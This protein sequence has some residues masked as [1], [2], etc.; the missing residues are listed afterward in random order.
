[1][2]ATL[3]AWGASDWERIRGYAP[4]LWDGALVTLRVAL[5]ALALG[6]AIGLAVAVGSR[7]RLLPVRLAIGAYV[8]VGRAVPELVQVFIWYYVLPDYGLVLSPFAAGV[9]AIGVAFGPYLGEVFRAGVESVDRTQ[10]EA[11]EVL[12][13]SRA[14]VWRRVILPQALRTVFPIWTSY[15]ISIFKAT[16]LLS[17]I[18]LREVFGV[19]RNEAALNFRYFELFALVMAIYLAMGVPMVIALR[20]LARRWDTDRIRTRATPATDTALVTG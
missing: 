12:G 2:R 3:L 17:F 11:G 5:F 4:E 20:A 18:S 15:L 19:A 16:S 7:S 1:M 14:Q 9:I 8:Q 13:L 6:T 10:W